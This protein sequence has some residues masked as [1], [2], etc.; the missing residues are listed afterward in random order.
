MNEAPPPSARRIAQGSPLSPGD[1]AIAGLVGFVLGAIYLRTLAPTILAA[2]GGEFQFAAYLA[3]IAHPT[4]YPLYLMLGWAWSHLLP[5]G[6]PAFRMNLFSALWAS[7]TVAVLY[8]LMLRLLRRLGTLSISPILVRP[9]AALAAVSF[10]VSEI[11][12]SQ[13]VAAE[14]YSLHAFL[15]VAILFLALAWDGSEGRARERLGLLLALTVGLA[16]AHHATTILILPGLLAF[17]WLRRSHAETAA[18]QPWYYVKMALC[19]ILPQLL[20]LYVP[21]RAPH[22]PYVRLPWTHGGAPLILYDNTFQGFLDYRLGRVFAGELGYGAESVRRFSMA[23]QLLAAQFTWVGVLLGFAGLIYL[24]WKRDFAFLLLTL[25]LYACQAAFNLVYFIG[26]IEVFFIPTYLVFAIWIA[27]GA[28]AFVELILRALT[29][30]ARRTSAGEN[31]SE[32]PPPNPHLR[33]R[34]LG[35]LILLPLITIPTVLARHNLPRVDLSQALAPRRGWEAF[36]ESDPPPQAIVVSNDRNEIMPLWYLQYVEGRRPDLTGVFPLVTEE[37]RF[38]NVGRTLQAAL[39]TGRPVVLPK[40]MPGLEVLFVLHD[41]GRYWHVVAPVEIPDS[42]QKHEAT[43][44]DALTLAAYEIRPPEATP[45]ANLE[46]DLYWR[47]VRELGGDY[48]TYVHLMDPSGERVV[49][50]DHRPG[51]DFYPTSLWEPGQLLLD[52]HQLT[53]PP[54]LAPGSYR[55]RVGAYLYPQMMELGEPLWLGTVDVR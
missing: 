16:L 5:L 31:P 9:V 19:L 53:L 35:S 13:A 48:T 17:L 42:A 29:R 24:V 4:G 11:F 8:L 52:R 50:S 27:L 43:L 22:T 38:A 10:G 37:A 40:A 21:L 26:D 32:D 39:E 34:W 23:G 33:H 14:V 2:D 28:G 30:P 7:L 6:D 44:E 41:E 49:G 1:L 55:L 18:P 12:W 15:T 20:Y 51:G 3:G 25:L 36:L 47:P 54:D 45:G 46:L